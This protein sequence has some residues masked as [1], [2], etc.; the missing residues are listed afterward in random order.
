[1]EGR[2]EMGRG[3]KGR[4]LMGWEGKERG[5]GKDEMRLKGKGW[6]WKGRKGKVRKGEG[7]E[8]TGRGRRG[9]GRG[10]LLT[11][12]VCLNQTF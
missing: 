7:R 3:R 6:V 9:K 2:D 4:E 8:G 12:K 10:F 11:C 1:M 5:D